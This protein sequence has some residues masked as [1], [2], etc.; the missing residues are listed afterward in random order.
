[1]GNP[2][3]YTVYLVGVQQSSAHEITIPCVLVYMIPGGNISLC[4]NI[5]LLL[6]PASF[7]LLK[8]II[9]L[10]NT[11][12]RPSDMARVARGSLALTGITLF[13]SSSSSFFR[14]RVVDSDGSGS[15]YTRSCTCQS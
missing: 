10:D 2:S 8:E 1:M 11:R 6:I 14:Q 4:L 15:I 9:C 5:A 3:W 7:F 13:L 12:V